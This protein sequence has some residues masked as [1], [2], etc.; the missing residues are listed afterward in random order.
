MR[1]TPLVQSQP[2]Y[3]YGGAQRFRQLGS[4]GHGGRIYTPRRYRR[5]ISLRN[6]AR[7]FAISW[8][9]TV[10]AAIACAFV[11]QVITNAAH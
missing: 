10:G 5:P 4:G 6:T 2:P 11:I 9:L 3:Q 7:R 8:A 1:G